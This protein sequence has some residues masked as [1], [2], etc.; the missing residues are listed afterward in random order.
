[1]RD[2]YS[3]SKPGNCVFEKTLGFHALLRKK[4]ELIHMEDVSKIPQMH[5]SCGLLRCD[6]DRHSP[7]SINQSISQSFFMAKIA[8]CPLLQFCIRLC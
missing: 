6:S 3:N 1:M 8:F 7:K 2:N 4:G 5:A